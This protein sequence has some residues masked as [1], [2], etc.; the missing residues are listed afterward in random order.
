MGSASMGPRREGADSISHLAC[1]DPLAPASMGPRREGADSH[2][3]NLQPKPQTH[4]CFNGAA[5]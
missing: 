3:L 5:P 1:S 2:R 4:S